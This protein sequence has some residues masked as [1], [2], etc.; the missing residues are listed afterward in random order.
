MR[1][2]LALGI[3]G[4][5]LIAVAIC[6]YRI[7]KIE[8]FYA[9]LFDSHKVIPTWQRKRWAFGLLILGHLIGFSRLVYPTRWSPIAY[10]VCVCAA[11]WLFAS[12]YK[13]FLRDIETLTPE[14]AREHSTQ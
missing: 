9:E 1:L 6:F 5:C 14:G 13:L 8:K 7:R 11:F 4:A 2:Y 10:L 3:F 12:A